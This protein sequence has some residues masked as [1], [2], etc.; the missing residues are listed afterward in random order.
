MRVAQ[1][2]GFVV[3]AE[4]STF[5]LP[6]VKRGLVP[7]LAAP[8]LVRRSGINHAQRM[9]LTG[10]TVD[11]ETALRLNMVD[12]VV[13]ADQVWARA[14]LWAGELAEGAPSS[15]Q[16]VRQLINETISE[17]LFT[18][19]RIGAANMAAAR[20]TEAARKG[21]QAFLDKRPVD[22]LA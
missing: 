3:A 22:W 21:V 6:E 13:Q 1:R 11:T 16:L 14:H 8:L 15:H 12:E 9:I 2:F 10:Q 7:G 4:S 5:G 17:E 20:S 18:Q 19:L